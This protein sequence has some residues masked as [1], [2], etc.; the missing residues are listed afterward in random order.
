MLYI[1]VGY[2]ECGCFEQ[3][4]GF[5]VGGW[6]F[7]YVDCLYQCQFIGVLFVYVFWCLFELFV[8]GMC[9]GGMGGIVGIQCY[10]QDVVG[11][12]G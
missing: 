5:N 7:V 1:D 10:L 9:E 2:L 11:V 3:V 12:V 4:G 6:G 8:E